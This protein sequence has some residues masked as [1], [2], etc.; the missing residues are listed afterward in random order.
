MEKPFLDI[1]QGDVTCLMVLGNRAVIGTE[2]PNP[3]GGGMYLAVEDNAE[4]VVG[5]PD[6]A[7][8]LQGPTADQTGCGLAFA[9]LGSFTLLPLE[10]GD[11]KVDDAAPGGL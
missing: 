11:V 1:Q 9:V 7:L 3:V 6:R 2:N 8:V 4:L 5:V 10:E